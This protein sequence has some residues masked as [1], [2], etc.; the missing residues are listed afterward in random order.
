MIRPQGEVLREYLE[1]FPRLQ[2]GVVVH[3][4]DIF[5][6]RDYLKTWGVDEVRF[7]NEQYLLEALLTN[8]NR[9]EVIAALNFLKNNHTVGPALAHFGWRNDDWDRI[10]RATMA[11]H[12]LECGS[13]VTGGYY[14]D[15]GYKDVPD[16]AHVGFPLAEI[17]A[18]GNCVLTKAD[19]TGGGVPDEHTMKEQ[20]LYEVHDPSAYLTPDVIAGIGDAHLETRG[21]HTV[22]LLGV[23]G[24]PRCAWTHR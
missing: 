22:A 11:G 24:H 6:P 9:Y 19:H 20:L 14:A 5:T 4:H 16:L 12:L 7:W 13:Q 8:T 15:P 10:G 3:I 18:D 1:I 23:R 21:E 2:P 17:D